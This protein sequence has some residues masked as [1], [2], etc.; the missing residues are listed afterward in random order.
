MNAL[1]KSGVKREDLVVFT[2]IFWVPGHKESDI[3]FN[4]IGLSRKHVIEVNFLLIT[5][6]LIYYNFL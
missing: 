5:P 1:I 2:K 4:S 3:G 6:P